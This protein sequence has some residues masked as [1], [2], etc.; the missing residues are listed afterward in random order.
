MGMYTASKNI[1][2]S[3]PVDFFLRE[4]EDPVEGIFRIYHTPGHCPGE[5]CI[6]V[7][8]VLFTGDHLLSHITPHQSPGAIARYT[9]LGHYLASL[10]KI[11][12]GPGLE[13]AFGGHQNVTDR[14]RKPYP[15]KEGRS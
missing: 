11:E 12:A 13:R 7:G 8:E 5:V 10:K 6:Q 9:G 15:N 1:L 3:V 4:S 14:P 2:S